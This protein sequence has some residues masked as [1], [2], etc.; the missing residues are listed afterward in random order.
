MSRRTLI[1][2]AMLYLPKQADGQVVVRDF[3]VWSSV[4]INKDIG[5]KWSVSLE[6]QIRL[7]HDAKQFDENLTQLE[8][9]FSP[10]KSWQF[11]LGFRE[12]RHRTGS[13]DFENRMRIHLDAGYSLEINRLEAGVRARIQFRSDEGEDQL[14]NDFRSRLMLDYNIPS[15]KLDPFVYGEVDFRLPGREPFGYYSFRMVLGL[16]WKISTLHRLRF[17]YMLEREQQEYYPFTANRLGIEYQ[18]RL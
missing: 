7:E 17:F 4:Q 11:S 15:W 13:G 6:N 2:I 10:F 8:L 16:I 1:I 18:I 12:I 14:L 9:D 3:Q 5:T